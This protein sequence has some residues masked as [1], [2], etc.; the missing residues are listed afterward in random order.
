MTRYSCNSRT[1]RILLVSLFRLCIRQSTLVGMAG[2][3]QAVAGC[4]TTDRLHL[5]KS[6]T[7]VIGGTKDWIFSRGA[8]EL[9]A[10]RIPGAKLVL[11][12]G[13]NHAMMTEMHGRFNRE[14]LAFLG[15]K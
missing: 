13:G 12:E 4:S 3:F 5:I 7:L 1:Y 6:P 2:Q 14:V 11:L 10:Q 8:T 9:L 15:A